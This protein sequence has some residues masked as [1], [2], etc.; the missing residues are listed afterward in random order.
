MGQFHQ[1]FT[2]LSARDTPIFSFPDD[3]LSKCQGILTNFVHASI[4]R[5]SVLEFGQILPVFDR[6]ICPD[7]ILAGYYGLMFLLLHIFQHKKAVVLTA[8]VHPGESNSSWMMKGFLDYLC[9]NSADAKV[10]TTI[11]SDD[12]LFLLFFLFLFFSN[13]NV[14]FSYFCTRMYV[15]LFIRSWPFYYVY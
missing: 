14:L 11:L 15:V 6:V 13:D 3:S 10:C 5:S 12:V 9:S 2:E 4:L 7:T 8:R 1:I